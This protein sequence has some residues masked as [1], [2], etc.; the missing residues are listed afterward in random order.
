M[1]VLATVNRHEVVMCLRCGP[2]TSPQETTGNLCSQIQA[3]E[4]TFTITTIDTQKIQIM[5]RTY[6]YR[7]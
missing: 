1:D 2:R 7:I 4:S 5:E 6:H 3:E